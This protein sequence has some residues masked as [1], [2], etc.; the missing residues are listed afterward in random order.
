MQ[1]VHIYSNLSLSVN[2]KMKTDIICTIINYPIYLLSY[3]TSQ[4]ASVVEISY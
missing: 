1:Q 3:S 4:S 2:S